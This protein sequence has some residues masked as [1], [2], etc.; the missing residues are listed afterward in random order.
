MNIA[1][2]RGTHRRRLSQTRIISVATLDTVITSSAVC[3]SLQAGGDNRV[4]IGGSHFRVWAPGDSGRD[5]MWHWAMRY[6]GSP[7][8]VYLV[9]TIKVD[10]SLVGRWDFFSEEVN[11][12]VANHL[13]KCP[14]GGL[15]T[16][17][18]GNISLSA[19]KGASQEQLSPDTGRAVW[20]K[21][22]GGCNPSLATRRQRGWSHS[23]G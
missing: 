21:F 1:Q 16:S 19:H 14:W 9:G 20:R 3:G 8:S 6:R 11:T 22:G 18:E 12:P 23:V 7:V 5:W 4:L 10:H 15:W 2:A 17:G 13:G